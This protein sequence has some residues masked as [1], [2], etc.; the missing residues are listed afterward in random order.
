VDVACNSLCIHSQLKLPSSSAV[1]SMI[2][3][4][5][6]HCT[7]M[8]VDHQYDDSHVQSTVV[9]VFCRLLGFKQLPRLKAIHKQKLYRPESGVADIY[10]NL[11][12][13]MTRPIDWTPIRQQFDQMVKYTTVLRPGTAET[14]S[15][16]RR[17]TRKNVQRPTYKTLLE[18]G[19]AI[20][21][22]FLFRHLHSEV[23]AAR[24]TRD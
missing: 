19:K 6:R 20:K 17:F 4:V 3:K 16:I 9:L 13:V 22:F 8:E 12:D 5:L 14:E 7:E 21:I 10:E 24:S 11:K 18:L 2:E 15:I 23:L 1:A